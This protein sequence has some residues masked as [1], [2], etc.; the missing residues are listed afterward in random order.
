MAASVEKPVMA[1]FHED[2]TLG[3]FF[4]FM[5][6]MAYDKAK[7][8]IVCVLCCLICCYEPSKDQSYQFL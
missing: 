8:H 6:Y 2:S 5:S 3:T 7:E 4:T 1:V